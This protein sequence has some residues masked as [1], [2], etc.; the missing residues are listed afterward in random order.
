[1]APYIIIVIA[2]FVVLG[3]CLFS[4]SIKAYKDCYRL[5]QVSMSPVL[6]FF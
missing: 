4:Y 3:I 6:S 5:S 2:V 1:M